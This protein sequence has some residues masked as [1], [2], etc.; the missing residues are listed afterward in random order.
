M[1][2]PHALLFF[3]AIAT[4]V[5]HGCSDFLLNTTS[6]RVVSARTLDDHAD[7]RSV[8]EIVPR[9]TRFQELATSWSITDCPECPTYAWRTTYG[10]VGLNPFGAHAATDGLNEKGLSA[11]VLGLNA[12]H[13]PLVNVTDS[14]TGQ[15]VVASIVTYILGNFATVADVQAGLR[16]AEAAEMSSGNH[17][18]D[19]SRVFHVPVH[20]AAGQSI[21]VEL[22]HSG[23]VRVLANPT[24]V[25]TNNQ[26]LPI[27]EAS[28]DAGLVIDQEGDDVR[29][30]ALW[31]G[32]DPATRLQRLLRLNRL[33]ASDGSTG[34]ASFSAATA[35][36]TTALKMIHTVVVEAGAAD[37]D[38]VTTQV[39][40][41][42]DHG[43][44]RLYFQSTKH[45]VLQ[46]LDL[47]KIDFANPCSRKALDMK[48]GTWYVNATQT[49]PLELPEQAQLDQL[50]AHHSILASFLDRSRT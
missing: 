50:V 43:A 23:G 20:D 34:G 12:S 48:Y 38:G 8:L 3:F 42:R 1:L 30:T 9:K 6:S 5:S 26:S 27:D 39:T 32:N 47:N 33:H 11:A 35:A 46:R 15:T 14:M 19:G 44:L 16:T 2:S 4:V 37:G 7:V 13:C 41:V 10:F 31:D 17:G 18:F 45:H 22:R 49:V 36:I 40:L 28:C 29:D 24:G 21:V 25:M